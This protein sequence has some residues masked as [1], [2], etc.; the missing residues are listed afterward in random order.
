VEEEEE[1]E[2]VFTRESITKEDPP[3][4]HQAHHHANHG[5][6]SAQPQYISHVRRC[7]TLSVVEEIQHIGA[8]LFEKSDPIGISKGTENW[9][10]ES[11]PLGPTHQQHLSSMLRGGRGVQSLPVTRCEKNRDY[12]F[13]LLLARCCRR[14]PR[15]SAKLTLVHTRMYG[16]IQAVKKAARADPTVCRP[17]LC[18]N[19]LFSSLL[20]PSLFVKC[21]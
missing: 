4:A 19:T 1:E 18:S 17:C 10:E 14:G 2:A 6:M 8:C 20:H 15:L 11:N 13:L 12:F 21:A 9:A 5:S 3:N 16:L 7:C